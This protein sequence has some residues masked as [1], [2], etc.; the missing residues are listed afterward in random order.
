MRQTLLQ[1]RQLDAG[2]TGDVLLV[3]TVENHH[4][5]DTVDEFRAEIGLHFL[6]HR[7]FDATVGFPGHLLDHL[8]AQ[9]GRHD[10]DGILEIHRPPLTVGHAAIVKHLQQNVEHIRMRLFHLVEENHA[11]R[12]APYGL[13][14]GSPLLVAN[15]AGRRADQTSHRML[16]HELAHVDA[17]QM[18]LGI[19]HEFSQCLAQ[20]RLANA[21]RP[22][23]EEGAVGAIGIGQ[24]RTRTADGIGHQT[25]GL[26]LANDTIVQASFHMQQLVALTLHHL[27]HRNAGRPTDHLGNFFSANLSTQQLVLRCATVAFGFRLLQLRLQLRQLAVLQFGHLVQFAFALQTRDLRP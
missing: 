22:Q 5:I 17:D 8:A 6:H 26:V 21:G 1:I 25:Y 13:G 20:L 2:D 16:L 24:T 14:Q 12:F 23:E 19:E 15:V 9:V 7:I 4:F 11:V 18:I 27:A 10:D 3:Q